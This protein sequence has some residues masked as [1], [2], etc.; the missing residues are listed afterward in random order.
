MTA[1][2]AKNYTDAQTAELIAEYTTKDTNNKTFNE[3]FAE[4]FGKTTRSIVAK[5]SK[6]GVYKVEQRTT[7]TGEK[8]I[9]KAELVTQINAKIG[10]E[11]DSLVKATKADLQALVN[12]LG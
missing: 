1:T 7:K 8:V 11:V 4:K 5:L 9:T 12:N 6:E 3:T 10:V 2:T